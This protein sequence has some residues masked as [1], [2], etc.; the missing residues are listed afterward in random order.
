MIY[1]CRFG[2][3]GLDKETPDNQTLNYL[4]VVACVIR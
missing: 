2:W 1:V 3:F 4:G